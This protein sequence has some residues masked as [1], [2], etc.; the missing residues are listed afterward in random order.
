MLSWKPLKR[1][2]ASESVILWYGP[3]DPDLYQNVMDPEHCILF[4]ISILYVIVDSVSFSDLDPL[5]APK[6]YFE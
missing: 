2:A 6:G 5:S 1:R 3:A 4:Y